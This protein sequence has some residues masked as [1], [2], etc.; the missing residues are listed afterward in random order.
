MFTITGTGVHLG[1]NTHHPSG[2]CLPSFAFPGGSLAFEFVQTPT[3]LVAIFET[4]PTYRRVYLDGRVHPKDLN[5]SWMGHSIGRWQEDTLVIDT[6]GFN[7][8]S[9]IGLSPHTEMLH[10]TERYRR[11]DRGHLEVTVTIEDRGPI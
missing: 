10:V 2:F 9:W 8:K 6:V 4:A 11:P 3:R 1:R 7:D 5:P